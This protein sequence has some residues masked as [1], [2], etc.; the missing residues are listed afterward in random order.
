MLMIITRAPVVTASAYFGLSDD[1]MNLSC[2]EG[3]Q[4]VWSPLNGCTHT[5][6]LQNRVA[7]TLLVVWRVSPA[8][9]PVTCG[10]TAT[11]SFCIHLSC[12]NVRILLHTVLL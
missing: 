8:Q 11:L 4:R 3:S 2:I 1:N 12:R 10:Q 6:L 5:Q 7:T 9:V